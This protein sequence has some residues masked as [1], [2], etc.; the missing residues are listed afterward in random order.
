[1]RGQPHVWILLAWGAEA[2][3]GATTCLDIACAGSSSRSCYSE[4]TP[5]YGLMSPASV[6]CG[7]HMC[8]RRN[9]RPLKD[10]NTRPLKGK[11][12][13]PLKDENTRPLKDQNTRPLKGKNT[14]PLRP[15]TIR[16]PLTTL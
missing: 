13:R 12:T 4:T 5:V 11:N 1:M 16:R 7:C 14:R 2:D 10:P 8:R 3:A 6:T 15:C 9:T